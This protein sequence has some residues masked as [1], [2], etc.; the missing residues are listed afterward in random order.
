MDSLCTR[1]FRS[2]FNFPG[3]LGSCVM[4]KVS[5]LLWTHEIENWL[6]CHQILE[7]KF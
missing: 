1:G 4:Y 6:T 2:I 3:F 7:E 5:V